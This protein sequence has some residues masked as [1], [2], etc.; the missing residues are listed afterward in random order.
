MN[1]AFNLTFIGTNAVNAPEKKPQKGTRV[2]SIINKLKKDDAWKF[3]FKDQWV[4]PYCCKPVC[5]DQEKLGALAKEIQFH[6]QEECPA[7]KGKKKKKAVPASKL[8]VMLNAWDL[9][10]T[11]ISNLKKTKTWQF[12]DRTGRW[13]CPSCGKPSAAQIMDPN[14]RKVHLTPEVIK[15]ATD[16]LNSCERFAKKS[17]FSKSHLQK[18]TE[19]INQYIELVNKFNSDK[20]WSLKDSQGTWLCPFCSRF[21]TDVNLTKPNSVQDIYKHLSMCPDYRENAQEHPLEKLQD[22][23]EKQFQVS[24]LIPQVKKNLESDPLWQVCDNFC[25]WKC[26]YCLDF[27]M[28]V[29]YGES[30][31]QSGDTEYKIAKHLVNGCKEYTPGKKPKLSLESLEEDFNKHGSVLNQIKRMKKDT[32]NRMKDIEKAAKHQKHML[33]RKPEINGYD[34]GV[35]FESLDE[36]SGDFYDFFKQDNGNYGIVVGDVS[37]HGIQAGIVMTMVK[38]AIEIH[39]KKIPGP[40]DGILATYDDVARDL[41]GGT[42]VTIFY[43]VIDPAARQLRFIRAGHNE[44]ILYSPGD[45]EAATIYSEGNLLC[46]V[47]KPETEEVTLDLE[48]GTVFIQY[49]D[50]ITEA[51]SVEGEEFGMERLRKSVVQFAGLSAQSITENIYNEVKAFASGV[52]EDDF[53]LVAIKSLD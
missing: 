13:I 44:P 23:V 45:S 30:S 3:F 4:C 21:I 52:M 37:G 14:T 22:K 12:F 38:K 5:D 7:R 33:T 2:L 53:T 25:R 51:K 18:I 49:T 29:Y 50:G 8:A 1:S 9:K 35:K 16:H 39:G 6:L 17:F 43:A 20:R 34:I 28:D 40:R 11:L 41:M 26:P 27:L 36:I 48:P 47:R 19:R 42:F 46:N 15:Q 32:T 10:E 31:S 24:K